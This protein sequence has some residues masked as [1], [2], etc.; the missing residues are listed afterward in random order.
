MYRHRCGHVVLHM[1]NGSMRDYM[2]SAEAWDQLNVRLTIQYYS[3]L[4]DLALHNSQ[5]IHGDKSKFR[6]IDEEG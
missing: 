1:Y 5:D 4:L 6:D 2:Q 3:H